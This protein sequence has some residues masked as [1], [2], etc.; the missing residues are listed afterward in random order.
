MRTPG[1][2]RGLIS[3]IFFFDATDDFAAVLAPKHHDD[4]GDDL[5]LPILRDGPLSDLP[6]QTYSGHVA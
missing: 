4:T 5:A 3:L 6:S 2:R 1:G